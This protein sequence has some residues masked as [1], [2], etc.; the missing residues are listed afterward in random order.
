M[1]IN[2]LNI[3]KIGRND[4]CNCGSGLKYKKCCLKTDEARTRLNP[5]AIRRESESM[6]KKI[7]KILELKDMSIEEMNRHIVGRSFDDINAEH[8]ELSAAT[9]KER[10]EDLVIDAMEETSSRERKRLAKE[11]L[12]IYPNLADAWIILADESKSA[13]EALELTERAVKAGYEDLG[14]KYIQ[15]HRGHFWGLT[16]TRPYMRAIS[17]LAQLQWS[18]GKED[19]AITNLSECLRLNPNDNQGVRDPLLTYLLL[20]NDLDG[21]EQLLKQFSEDIGASHQYNSAL[22]LYKRHGAKS[23]QALL[24]LQKAYDENKFVRNYLLGKT[25]L[26]LK[27][28]EVYSMG[29]QEEAM[30]YAEEAI[31]AWVTTPG[32]LEWLKQTVS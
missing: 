30:I 32:A 17:N 13:E 1:T 28:P 15:E 26:P 27:T 7:G 22:Y 8:N 5:A 14:E 10:A 23:D 25:K 3:S 11:A 20:R 6:M 16:E 9:A 12:E 24:Q 29:S 4:P 19:E 18:I 31:K 21:A 2:G